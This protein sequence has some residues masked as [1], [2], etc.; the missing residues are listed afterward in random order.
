MSNVGKHVLEQ[1]LLDFAGHLSFL[2]LSKQDERAIE[3]SRRVYLME[4]W[5]QE[6]QSE[7]NDSMVVPES[8]SDC[9]EDWLRVCHPWMM[10]GGRLL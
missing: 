7:I 3:Q 9:P 4:I 10:L 1:L 8:H 2:G 6:R 5:R